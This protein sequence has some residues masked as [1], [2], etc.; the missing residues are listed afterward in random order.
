[1]ATKKE[2]EKT[3]VTMET[4]AAEVAAMLAQAREEAA[5]IVAEARQ[6]AGVKIPDPDE[7]KR[8]EA[9]R[10]RGEELVEVKLFRDN[11][12]YKDDVFVSC[13]GETIAI[14][15]GEK[16]KIKR[17]FAEILENSQRQDMETAR[18]V[19]KKSKEWEAASQNL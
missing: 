10:A 11:G 1:M 8:K 17:K 18:L 3:A 19:E 2:T 14:K 13:N 12:K 15:R 7:I 16:V 4:V 5:R 9:A 6:A